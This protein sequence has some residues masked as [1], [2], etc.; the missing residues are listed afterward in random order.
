M[1]RI[2]SGA[3][4]SLCVSLLLMLP[5]AVRGQSNVT[6]AL[7]GVVQD[8]GGAVLPGAA[9][10]VTNKATGDTIRAKTNGSGFYQFTILQPSQYT[11]TAS[12]PRFNTSRQDT[13]VNVGQTTTVN[14]RLAVGSA[15]Q[16]VLVSSLP[17]TLQTTNADISTTLETTQLQQ[18]PV[19]G[20]DVNSLLQMSPG[21]VMTGDLFPSMYGIT[22]NSNLLIENGMEDINPDGNST[23]GGSSN[24]LLGLNEIQ[25][26]TVSATEYTGQYGYLAGSNDT[27]VTKSGSN[28]FHGNAKYFWNGRAFNANDYFNNL[29]DTPRPFDNVNQWAASVGGPILHDRLFFFADTEGVR[30]MLPTSALALIPSQQFEAATIENLTANGLTASIPFYCQNLTLTDASGKTVT[31]PAGGGTGLGQGIFNLYNSAAGASRAVPGNGTDPLGCNGFTGLGSGVPCALN[32]RS[33]AGNFNPEEIL[34]SRIDWNIN[35]NNHIFGHFKVDDG[36]QATYTD[37]IN[38]LFDVD[39][40]QLVQ[41]GA[42]SWT[43]TLSASLVNEFDTSVEHFHIE[44]APPG[45]PTTAIAPATLAAF[46][47]DLQFGDGTFTTLG[48]IDADFPAL[49]ALTDYHFSDDLTKIIH[50][51][52]LKAGFDFSRY[53][54]GI[55]Y[56]GN[57]IGL[58][59]ANTADAFFDGG[60]DQASVAAGGSDYS[61]LVQSFLTNGWEPLAQAHMGGFIQDSWKVKDAFTLTL[62]LRL[63]HATN[64]VCQKNCFARTTVPFSE[65]DHNVDTPYNKALVTGLHQGLYNLQALEWQPRLGFAWQPFGVNRATVVRGGIGLFYDNVPDNIAFNQAENSPLINTFIASSG[66]LAPSQ[67]GNLFA[68]TASDTSAF[69]SGYSQGYTLAQFEAAVPGFSPPQLQEAVAQLPEP[70][71]TKW[72]LEVERAL[73]RDAVATVGYVGNHEIHGWIQNGS[74]NAYATGFAGLPATAPDPRFGTVTLMEDEG[75]SSY[76]G[77]TIQFAD[78]F[79]SSVVQANYTYSHALTDEIGTGNPRYI[80]DP[81]NPK[82]SYGNANFDV[83]SGMTADYVWMVPFAKFLHGPGALNSLIDGWQLS[84]TFYVHSGFPFTV[85]DSATDAALAGQNYSSSAGVPAPAYGIFANFNGGSVPSCSSPKNACLLASQFTSAATGF[86]NQA[87]NQFRGPMFVES[88]FG[89][90]KMTNIPLREGMKFGIGAQAYNIF[91]H[92]N[93]AIPDPDLADSTFGQIISA[94]GSPSSLFGV[95]LGGDNSPRL[96]QIKGVLEF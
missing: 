1:Q 29:S 44:F 7:S 6:G 58:L 4:F 33:T 39:S 40:A 32:F 71:V 38:P 92:P 65:L 23:N 67:S 94:V 28:Q 18:V 80:E 3:I 57:N 35:A 70:L 59:T 83:H 34:T 87:L 21:A 19:P 91:N 95:G 47:T 82:L 16:T 52:S 2:Y 49:Q 11:V 9:I 64:P 89:L 20:N 72:S 96:L 55:S 62:A 27:I 56:Y 75:I 53:D 66:P 31:C 50:D 17:P 69:T 46:P 79:G 43:S 76:N 12:A 73:W 85:Y 60:I 93:F 77:A 13:T 37:P 15:T 8:A 51:H 30:I 41:T 88:D 78:H 22:T 81:Y 24:L 14:F 74:V 86:G 25:E 45:S 48:G 63:D 61:T 36:T 68:Q 90:M 42:F 54:E 84:E 26:V 10:T 5:I